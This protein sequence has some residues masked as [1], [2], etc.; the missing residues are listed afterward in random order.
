MAN[1]EEAKTYNEFYGV[2]YDTIVNK[3]PN[4]NK[5]WT[6]EHLE[7]LDVCTKSNEGIR[8]MVKYFER[9]GKSIK[10]MQRKRAYERLE[11][12][13][14][15]LLEFEYQDKYELLK[16]TISEIKFLKKF[17]NIN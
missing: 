12:L 11:F 16:S 7:M 14:K 5:V 2:Y 15:L 17:L 9:K 13:N 1:N 6:K 10:A 3:Q 4:D 8:N